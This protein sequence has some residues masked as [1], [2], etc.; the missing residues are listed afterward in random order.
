M[1]QRGEKQ[2]QGEDNAASQDK[3]AA[4]SH[5]TQDAQERFNET[6]DQAGQ[7]QQQAHLSLA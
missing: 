2:S 6:A 4:F 7:A 5:I 1:A 3:D